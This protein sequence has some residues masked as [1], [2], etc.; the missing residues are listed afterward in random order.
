[1]IVFMT[2]IK[3]GNVSDLSKDLYLDSDLVLYVVKAFT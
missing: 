2:M 1:M 3:K